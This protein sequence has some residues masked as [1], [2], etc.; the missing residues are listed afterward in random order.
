M[1]FNFQIK[2][3]ICELFNDDA[4]TQ[5]IFHSAPLYPFYGCI[6]KCQTYNLTYVHGEGKNKGA[7]S[8]KV[9][10]GK[11][12]LTKKGKEKSLHA[13]ERGKELLDSYFTHL[14][15]AEHNENRLRF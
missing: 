8:L 6:L 4:H 5:L 13:W 1:T 10:T 2:Y 14:L 15:Y 3:E 7:S 12:D 11:K 9:I